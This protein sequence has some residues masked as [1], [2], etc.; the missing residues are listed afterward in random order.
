LVVSAFANVLMAVVE[1]MLAT[2]TLQVVR[3]ATRYANLVAQK[4]ELAEAVK[5]ANVA[6]QQ[7]EL[8]E[9]VEGASVAREQME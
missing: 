9:A 2:L 8:A 7:G 6:A 4:A 3:Q 5:Y 1:T